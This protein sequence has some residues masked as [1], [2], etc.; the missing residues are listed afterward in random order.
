MKIGR[1]LVA[2]MLVA[3]FGRGADGAV[4][5]TPPTDV[6]VAGATTYVECAIRNVSEAPLT[7]TAELWEGDAIRE[8]AGFALPP[9][10][11][12][13]LKG[14]HVAVRWSCKFLLEGG[15]TAGR[16]FAMATTVTSSAVIPVVIPAQ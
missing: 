16:A 3:G 6:S 14:R 9:G 8:A 15:N 1:A 4:L 10:E 11:L 7:V 13:V 2:A 12:T 5:A